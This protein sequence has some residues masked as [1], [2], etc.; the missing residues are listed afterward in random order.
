V[1][2]Y[3]LINAQIYLKQNH[4]LLADA[5]ETPTAGYTLCNAAVG[6]DYK[7]KKGELLFS[8]IVSVNNI[9]DIAYQSHLSRLKYAPENYATGRAGVFN[10]GRNINLKL[11]IPVNY[12]I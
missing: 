9:F 7:N 2:F 8:A 11:M 3:G 10:M 4:V 1:N 6:S 5:T 12:K